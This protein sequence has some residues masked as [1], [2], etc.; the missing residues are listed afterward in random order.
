MTA[1][2]TSAHD[3]DELEAL[4]DSIVA[5]NARQSPSASPTAATQPAAARH[6]HAQ[7]EVCPAE[8]VIARVG[9]LTRAL[10]ESLRELGYDEVLAKAANVIPDTHDRLSY[11]ASMTESAATRVLTATEAAQPIQDRLETESSE[12][13]KGW[14]RVFANELSVDE[15]KDLATRTRA[16]L[17]TVPDQTRATSKHLLEIMMAQD[18]QDLTG[19]VIKK[20]IDVTSQLEKQL[21]SLLL[22]HVPPGRKEAL[23]SSGLAGPVVNAASRPDTLNDQRQ[24]DELLESLGF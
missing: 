11:I 9:Q 20:T 13:A 2:S 23:E 22:E 5:E 24:V 1:Q 10:H 19:Q 12:L 6:E 4:F 14:D 3:S 17:A 15:F 16:F 21:L 7:S 18:F 8:A